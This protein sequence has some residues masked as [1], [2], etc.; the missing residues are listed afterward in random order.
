[1]QHEGIIMNLHPQCSPPV[2]ILNQID[3]VHA[4]TFHFPKIYLNIILPSTPGSSKWLLHSGY[5]TRSLY[6]PLLSPIRATCPAHLTLLYL[7]TRTILGEG[8]R[9]LSSSLCSLLHSSVTSS[10]LGPNILLHTLFSN[11]LSLR[12]P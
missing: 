7:V 8:Y 4:S 9:S 2:P 1:V 5:P 10:L 12:S 3:P 11:I 6:M